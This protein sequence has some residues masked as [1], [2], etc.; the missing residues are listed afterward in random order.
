MPASPQLRFIRLF[1]RDYSS[2][3]PARAQSLT[4]IKEASPLA[5]FI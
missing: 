1:K 4:P 3:I 5:G 2:L